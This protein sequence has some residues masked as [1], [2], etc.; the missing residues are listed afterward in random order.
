LKL[1]SCRNPP[2]IINHFLYPDHPMFCLVANN[3]S[4]DSI[5]DIGA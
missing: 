5:Q 1:Y 3:N 4:I 2:H